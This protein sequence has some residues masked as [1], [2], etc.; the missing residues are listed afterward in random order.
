[1][2]QLSAMMLKRKNL[3]SASI[4]LNESP[5]TTVLVVTKPIKPAQG[6]S[7]VLICNQ[8]KK[9]SRITC[10]LQ[11]QLKFLETTLLS[12][13]ARPCVR[14]SLFITDHFHQMRISTVGCSVPHP[15]RMDTI[16]SQSRSRMVL[17]KLGP[18][19]RPQKVDSLTPDSWALFPK[20]CPKSG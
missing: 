3:Y 16:Q 2:H 14:H 15:T 20:K 5:L 8:I 13:T 11:T 1:M 17:G 10:Y 6:P 18:T 19:V 4:H 12:E 7:S 9:D